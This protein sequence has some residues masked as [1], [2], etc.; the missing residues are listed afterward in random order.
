GLIH[1]FWKFLRTSPRA[2]LR[3]MNAGSNGVGSPGA[4]PPYDVRNTRLCV[5]M[6]NIPSPPASGHRDYYLV[7]VGATGHGTQ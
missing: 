6:P 1:R 2:P 3:S 7:E 5:V 4:S